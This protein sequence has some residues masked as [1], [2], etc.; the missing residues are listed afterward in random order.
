MRPRTVV[1][2]LTPYLVWLKAQLTERQ[3]ARQRVWKPWDMAEALS[4]SVVA[5][6]LASWLLA[7]GALLSQGLAEPFRS[8]DQWSQVW[9][10]MSAVSV[11]LSLAFWTLLGLICV[12]ALFVSEPLFSGD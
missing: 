2:C 6:A 4:L 3:A 11:P 1:A 12:A 5:L 7:N 10:L 9:S 8:L